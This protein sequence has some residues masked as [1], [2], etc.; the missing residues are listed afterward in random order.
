MYGPLVD[1]SRGQ[2]IH[3]SGTYFGRGSPSAPCMS[4]GKGV[5]SGTVFREKVSLSPVPK[6]MHTFNSLTEELTVFWVE[7]RAVTGAWKNENVIFG[8]L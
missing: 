5:G 2:V 3:D 7:G 4:K 8:E 6:Q 1:E